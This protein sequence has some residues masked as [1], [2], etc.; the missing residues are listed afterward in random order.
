MSPGRVF[1]PVSGPELESWVRHRILEVLRGKA[2]L[3]AGGMRRSATLRGL[4]TKARKPMDTCARYLITYSPYLRYNRYLAK[5]LP[6]AT[7][8]IEGA[9]RHLVKDRMDVTCARWSLT[10]AEAVLRLRALRSSRDF[11]EYWV[12]HEAC[13]HARIHQARYAGGTVPPTTASI[14]TRK[15]AHLKVIK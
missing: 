8:V 11:D 13:E 12:F 10:G 9:C 2:G 4:S 6:I 7:G 14:P 1:H 15:R 5:G 3:V